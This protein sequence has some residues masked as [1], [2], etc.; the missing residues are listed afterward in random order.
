MRDCAMHCCA[1]MV[2]SIVTLAVAA[3]LVVA[4]TPAEPVIYLVSDWGTLFVEGRFEGRPEYWSAASEGPV[5]GGHGLRIEP[6]VYDEVGAATG[7]TVI[8]RVWEPEG[9]SSIGAFTTIQPFG[10]GFYRRIA[11]ASV[12]A[13]WRFIVGNEAAQFNANAEGMGG[14]T[15][16]SSF[17]LYD[18]TD[19]LLVAQLNQGPGRGISGVLL[20]NHEYTMNFFSQSAISG[21]GDPYGNFEFRTNATIVPEPATAVLLLISA[22][23]PRQR[24]RVSRRP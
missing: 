23:F 15:A 11:R 3:L 13:T 22:F 5:W 14:S 16:I 1:R 7:M 17:T 2:R 9:D 24:S 18:E 8:A 19:E 21:G 12:N 20:A 4:P 10:T 6:V